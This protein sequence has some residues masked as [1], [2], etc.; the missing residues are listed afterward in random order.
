[1]ADKID[2]RLSTYLKS[3]SC[4]MPALAILSANKIFHQVLSERLDG[5][6]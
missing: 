6:R 2:A 4:K 1:M 3:S 5:F